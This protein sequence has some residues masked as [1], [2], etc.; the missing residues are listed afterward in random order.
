MTPQRIFCSLTVLL[1]LTVY[2]SF[3]APPDRATTENAKEVLNA[4][5]KTPEKSIPPAVLRDAAGVIIA[6]DVVKG[7]LVIGG[8]RGHG[9]L[10][11]REKDGGWSNPIF[12]TLAGASL[13]LQIGIESTDLFLVV[14]NARSLERIMRNTGKITLGT[15][16]SVAAGPYGRQTGTAVDTQLKA[17]ILSYSH[18]RGV[19]A[20]VALDGGTIVLDRETND[21]FYYKR[22]V[23]VPEIVSGAMLTV[24]ASAQK[25][26]VKMA[27]MSGIKPAAPPSAQTGPSLPPIR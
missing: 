9:V 13:G 7:G 24:P 5:A 1:G 6:H 20:G 15:D 19:F 27:E 2:P 12:V 8:Q 14:R 21:Y 17:E 18:T 10:L 25:L 26:R 22:G 16:A 4:M 3:S 11:M 23:T